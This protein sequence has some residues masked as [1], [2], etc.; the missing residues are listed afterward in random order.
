MAY[1]TAQSIARVGV[2]AEVLDDG[3]RAVVELFFFF[4]RPILMSIKSQP[5]ELAGMGLNKIRSPAPTEV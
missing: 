3:A 2:D 4:F 1:D 5:Q